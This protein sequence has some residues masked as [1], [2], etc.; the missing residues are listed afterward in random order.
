MKYTVGNPLGGTASIP[1]LRALRGRVPA[2]AIRPTVLLQAV[3]AASLVC[4]ASGGA[5]LSALRDRIHPPVCEPD[6]LLSFVSLRRRPPT[7]GG[8]TDRR[9]RQ[10][11]GEG[12]SGWTAEPELEGRRRF[13]QGIPQQG[14]AAARQAPRLLKVRDHRSAMDLRLGQPNGQLCGPRRLRSDVPALPSTVRP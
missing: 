2:V 1:G 14:R 7:Q 4:E 11:M 12:R 9:S 3:H 8:A 5:D 6:L 13:V 10:G